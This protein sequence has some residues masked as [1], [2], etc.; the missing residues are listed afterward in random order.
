MDIM[1]RRSMLA[2]LVAAAGAPAVAAQLGKPQ[3]EK[4]APP[5]RA[6]P[7]PGAE[8]LADLLR[9][10]GS[11]NLTLTTHLTISAY[12][13]V[14]S[15][16][17]PIIGD[18]RFD[19]AAIVFP[20]IRGCASSLTDI[21]NVTSTLKFNEQLVSSKAEY[22]ED[23]A[24]GTRLARWEMKDKVGREVDLK[25]VIPMTSWE[26]VFD[27]TAA[28]AVKW[29]AAYPKAAAST[30][31]PDDLANF[32]KMRILDPTAPEIT[33]LL[34]TWTGG[35]D[36]KNVMPV[37]LAKFLLGKTIEHVQTS[38]D[39]LRFGHSGAFAG[40]ELQ[41]AAITAVSGRCSEHDLAN[42]LAT[43]YR[44]AGL[45][46]RT[47]IGYDND[48][49]T[50]DKS[51]F[52][53]R[54]TGAAALRSWVEFALFDDK[55]R[56]ELWVPVDPFRQRRSGTRTPPLDRKW[57]Y[58]GSISDLDVTLPF[59]FQYHPPTTVVAHGYPAFWGWL[60]TPELQIAEQ[61]LTIT[62]S[63]TAQRGGQK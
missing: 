49:G 17:R 54:N 31:Q 5:P 50:E 2:A 4:K 59:A 8:P 6:Q 1:T 9:R 24:A 20:V 51:R 44:A 58:F 23:Y 62:A 36:P 12:N 13:K 18:L 3:E 26:T 41:P 48:D 30:L 63:S 11:Q 53:R 27:E 57:E 16:G 45:P 28:M 33:N 19:T 32:Q 61:K 43:M 56:Q 60:T 52:L 29:P 46:A 47:V 34:K 21:A 37:E 15:A 25:I 42:F 35:R 38:G 40:M 10:G 14:D 22:A 7:A 55:G 39:G